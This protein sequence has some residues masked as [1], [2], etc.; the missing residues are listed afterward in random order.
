MGV[1]T[2]CAGSP[3]GWGSVMDS[4]LGK[5]SDPQTQKGVFRDA[6]RKRGLK[7]NRYLHGSYSG[8]SSNIWRQGNR[9]APDCNNPSCNQYPFQ[10]FHLFSFAT[11]RVRPIAYNHQLA[12]WMPKFRKWDAL[13]EFAVEL[14]RKAFAETPWVVSARNPSERRFAWQRGCRL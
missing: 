9:Y 8:V 1:V 12:A 13:G 7:K 11:A 2:R 4:D 5:Q 6:A 3:G 10:I 14:P